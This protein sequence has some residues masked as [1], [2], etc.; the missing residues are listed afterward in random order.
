MSGRV[1]IIED[2]ELLSSLLAISLERAGHTA[3]TV[4]S[5]DDARGILDQGGIDLVVSDHVLDG[6][7]VGDE[8][9]A[10]C[11]RSGLTRSA[12]LISGWSD[13]RNPANR[14]CSVFLQ[15][16][17]SMQVFLDTVDRLLDA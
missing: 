16:P 10:E 5:V 6:Q 3:Q 17:F 8:F 4:G 2:D 1:L 14:D 7:H 12:I 13:M 15:K 9:T 11:V